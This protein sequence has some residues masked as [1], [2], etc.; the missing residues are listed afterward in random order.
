MKNTNIRK[1]FLALL[2]VLLMALLGTLSVQ[3]KGTVPT[4]VTKITAVQSPIYVGQEFELKAAMSPYNADDDY[5][6]WSIVGKSGIIKFSDKDR[7]GDE[8]DF[9]A[10]KAG[11]TKVR[12]SVAGKSTTYSKTFTVTVKKATYKLT[13]VTSKNVTLRV[14]ADVDL[15][16]KVAGKL[17]NRYLK[18]TIAN[19]SILKF[20]DND[21]Y[22]DDV[23]V[24]GK[25][26]GKT[27]V[28]CKNLKTKKTIKFNVTVVNK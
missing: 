2:A 10:L 22:G 24:Y 11:T 3:A 14:G 16:V 9:V 6:R 13:R 25:K 20:E 12:C 19:T 28:T 7:D 27:T 15:K 26:A 21:R 5:L 17:K 23:E 8:I 18:W 1:H 4:K